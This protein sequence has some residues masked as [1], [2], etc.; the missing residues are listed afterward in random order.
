MSAPGTHGVV[1]P[2]RILDEPAVAALLRMEDLVDLMERTLADF[3]SG[4]VLQPVRT[5]LPIERHQSLLAVMP[6]YLPGS[7]ALAVK[8]VS[9]APGNVA[10][11]LPSH[12]ATILLVDP[13]TGALI[14]IMDG[15]LITEMRTAAV[16]AAAARALARPGASVLALIGSGVQA[17]SHL[18]A[19]RLVRPLERVRVW[20]PTRERREAFARDAERR[21]GLAV[22]AAGSA[23]EAV[24]SADLVVTATS[25]HVPV[26]EG[27]WLAPGTHVTGVG[28]CRP[29]QREVDAETVRRA[30]VWVDSA[31]AA[32]VE[33]GDLLLAE[34][35]GVPWDAR[36]RGEIGAV[37]EGSL[38]GRRDPDEITLFE[39]LGLAVEDAATALHVWR[40]AEASPPRS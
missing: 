39:S 21:F 37:F 14:A 33:A 6:G 26:L 38:P 35:E 17:K 9:V 4:R 27:R 5:V 11:G 1:A 24:R 16:S 7:G 19:L 3:S 23:A 10:R 31:A 13:E 15:R 20:S 29:D 36:V 2:P 40:K 34:R 12:L 8:V 30:S 32:R 18:E 28:A 22:E 25:S